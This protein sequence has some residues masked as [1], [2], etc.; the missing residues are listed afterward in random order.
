MQ[1]NIQVIPEEELGFV[2]S[3]PIKRERGGG[4]RGSHK[5]RKTSEVTEEAIG[6]GG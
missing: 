1:Q 6:D 2:E 3:P 5:R 4:H